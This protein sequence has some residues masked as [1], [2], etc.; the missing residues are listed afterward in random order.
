MMPSGEPASQPVHFTGVA[1]RESLWLGDIPLAPIDSGGTL[2]HLHPDH[3][4]APRVATDAAGQV[5]WQWL[6]EPFGVTAANEDPDGDGQAVTVNLRFPGQYH[7]AETGL[8]YNWHRYYD[9]ETG[10]YV[11][12]DPIGQAGGL[13]TYLYGYANPVLFTDP[14]GLWGS[15]HGMVQGMTGMRPDQLPRSAAAARH[16]ICPGCPHTAEAAREKQRKGVM[17]GL[18]IV[19]ATTAVGSVCIGGVAGAVLAG[20][21]VTTDGLSAYLTYQHTKD[22][23][24]SAA[25]F[26]PTLSTVL[27]GNRVGAAVAVGNA[28]ATMAE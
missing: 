20:T 16:L 25:Q 12:S 2:V 24:Q 26:M 28:A 8:H 6:G 18:A 23:E 9:P 17:T 27:F 22:V 10:R 13:N 19:G 3:L 11:T 1:V 21:S 5:V 4:N 7:D 15:H 14:F